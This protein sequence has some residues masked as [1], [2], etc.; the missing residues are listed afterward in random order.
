MRGIILRQDSIKNRTVL[1][2]ARSSSKLRYEENFDLYEFGLVHFAR[3]HQFTKV[4][5]KRHENLI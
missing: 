2:L 1:Y 3:L 5:H 4:S